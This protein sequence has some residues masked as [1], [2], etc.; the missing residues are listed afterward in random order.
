M[1]VSRHAKIIE[2][3]SQNDIETQEELAE[4][5]NRAGFKVTQ[6]TVS[7]DIRDLKL[8]KVSVGGSRQKYEILKAKE[9]GMSEKYIRVLKDGYVSMDMAQNILVIK[10]VSG[11]AMAVA[12]AVDAM[13]WKEVV[14]CI[15][16]D[17]TIM[18]AIRSVEDTTA[19]MDKIRKIV[20]KGN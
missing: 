19:V 14:G 2:L 12:A 7:R 1:K 9:D 17:D 20:A 6:A 4:Y 16:G 11:M 10:T 18:C 3:I 8:T 13:K 5:L 15:A